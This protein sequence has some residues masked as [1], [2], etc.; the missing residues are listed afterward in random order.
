MPENESLS[1]GGWTGM[2]I[3]SSG[4]GDAMK[5][6]IQW[7]AATQAKIPESYKTQCESQNLCTDMACINAADVEGAA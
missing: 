4:R 5:Y 2:I 6:I 1:I 7:D 3:E